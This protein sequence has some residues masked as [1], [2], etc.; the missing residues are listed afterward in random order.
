MDD[1]EMSQPCLFS[2]PCGGWSLCFPFP[3]SFLPSL[4]HFHSVCLSFSIYL[5]QL[6]LTNA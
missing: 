4:P 2:M 5:L 6:E 3:P 1:Q